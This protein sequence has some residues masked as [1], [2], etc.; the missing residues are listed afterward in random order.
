YTSPH[1]GVGKLHLTWTVPFEPGTLTAIARADGREVARD[2]LVTA[3]PPRAVELTTGTRAAAVVAGAMTFVTASIV[4]AR[5]VVVPGAEPVLRFTVRGPGRVA[6][7]DNG[8]QELAQSYQQP[9]IP[10]FKGQAVAVI[11]ATGGRGPITVT[12]S[13][14][15]LAAGTITL[16]G[17]NLGQRNGPGARAVETAVVP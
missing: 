15:G 7:V 12:A 16:P 10:A 5:R 2:E 1:G 3:G 17:T 13:A 8:R 14:P 6:G 4:D 11:A 9:T